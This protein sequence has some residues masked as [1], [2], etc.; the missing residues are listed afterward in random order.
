[1]TNL[2]V[3]VTV[4]LVT[5][6]ITVAPTDNVRATVV[7]A[8]QITPNLLASAHLAALTNS[9]LSGTIFTV[10]FTNVINIVTNFEQGR[11]IWE[12]VPEHIAR[13]PSGYDTNQSRL[14]AEELRA[15]YAIPTNTYPIGFEIQK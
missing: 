13:N 15:S 11:L 2:P 6:Q 8:I 4:L 7:S 10:Y 9:D 1:M 14:T 3:M 5:N 12:K